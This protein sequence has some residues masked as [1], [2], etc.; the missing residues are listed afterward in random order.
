VVRRANVRRYY[1]LAGDDVALLATS[2]QA[3]IT[4]S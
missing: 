1:A 2:L 4:V 3:I